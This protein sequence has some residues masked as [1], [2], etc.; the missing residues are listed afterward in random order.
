M[1][2]YFS[3]S[4]YMFVVGR[5]QCRRLLY[6][7]VCPEALVNFLTSPG[8]VGVRLLVTGSL[9]SCRHSCICKWESIVSSFP[10]SIL[11]IF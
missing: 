10:I 6:V 2:S 7:D 4:F 3:F 5:Y 8:D 11:L 1:A 9:T